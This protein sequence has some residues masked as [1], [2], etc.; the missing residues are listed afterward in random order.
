MHGH[1]IVRS[2]LITLMLLS[3]V[4]TAQGQERERGKH[5]EVARA[6]GMKGKFFNGAPVHFVRRTSVTRGKR[7]VAWNYIYV[8]A[9]GEPLFTVISSDWKEARAFHNGLAAVRSKETGKWGYMNE[10]GRLAIPAEFHDAKDF[11]D[12]LAPVATHPKGKGWVF[13]DTSG[14]TVFTPPD[15]MNIRYAS[16]H[17][18]FAVVNVKS[19]KALIDREGKKL[20]GRDYAGC[21]GFSEGLCAAQQKGEGY[22]YIDRKGKTVIA[23]PF[24]Y[25]R[26]FTDGFARVEDADRNGF[27]IDRAGKKMFALAANSE[28]G[29]FG[30]GLF[31]R[32][33]PK[34]KRFG[35]VDKSGAWVLPARYHRAKRFSDGFAAVTLEPGKRQTGRFDP[36]LFKW[37]FI[38][39]QGK[40]VLAA[41]YKWIDPFEN[42]IAR[43]DTHDGLTQF[44]RKDGSVVWSAKTSAR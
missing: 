25:A 6:M 17:D 27:L 34:E 7:V 18:G 21:V 37:G 36:P 4:A 20:N 12:G 16:F 15:G 33:D 39:K 28:D 29:A 38:D 43:V 2:R 10:K 41:Q 44:I 35:F 5:I 42:G 13:I 9:R 26:G 31:A 30:D 11:S 14:K 1:G 32:Y 24:R 40:L 8:N 23:G 19:G 3:A 22:H